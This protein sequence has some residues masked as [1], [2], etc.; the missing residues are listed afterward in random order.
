MCAGDTNVYTAFWTKNRTWPYPDFRVERKCR[1]FQTVTKYSYAA[2]EG[3]S[4][5]PK[6]SKE[7][8]LYD[9]PF[10]PQHLEGEE[11]P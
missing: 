3:I 9:D 2:M 1:D 4:L 5:L 11:H 6:P 7:V 8:L 10:R